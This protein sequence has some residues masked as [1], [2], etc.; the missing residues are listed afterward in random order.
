MSALQIWLNTQ[1]VLFTFLVDCRPGMVFLNSLVC[2]LRMNSTDSP[3]GKTTLAV[4]VRP[5]WLVLW[6]W[7]ASYASARSNRASIRFQAFSDCSSS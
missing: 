1:A 7:I 5:R 6:A 4:A 3:E 2:E